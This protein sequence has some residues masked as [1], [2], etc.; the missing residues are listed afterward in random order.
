M[1]LQRVGHDWVTEHIQIITLSGSKIKIPIES[2][3]IK[4]IYKL[5]EKKCTLSKK[6]CW[7]R[8]VEN[9]MLG[10]IIIYKQKSKSAL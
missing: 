5:F 3:K 10:K 7:N 2:W 6:K 8:N 1:E 9:Q 4:H